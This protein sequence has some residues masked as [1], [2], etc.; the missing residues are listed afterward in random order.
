MS[1]GTR[2]ST[3][4]TVAG[5]LVTTRGQTVAHIATIINVAVDGQRVDLE[6][7]FSVPMKL[8]P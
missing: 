5:A 1:F 4:T 8:T 3:K 6:Y 2:G 7:A